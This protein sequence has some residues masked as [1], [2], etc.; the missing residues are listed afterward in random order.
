MDAQA[1]KKK[2]ESLDPK[3]HKSLRDALTAEYNRLAGKGCHAESQTDPP[4]DCPE[5]RK[6]QKDTTSQNQ[7]PYCRTLSGAMER[8]DHDYYPDA[9]GFFKWLRENHPNLAKEIEGLEAKFKTP[10]IYRMDSKSFKF[11]MSQWEELHRKGIE[12]FL[13]EMQR[14]K[15]RKK[16]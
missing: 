5:N 3:A 11:L 14:E 16:P 6:E 1:L 15:R 7:V 10:L 12:M 8:I 13:N 4:P 9:F 2:I